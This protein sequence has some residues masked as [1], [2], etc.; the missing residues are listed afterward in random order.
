MCNVIKEGSV[1]QFA[2]DT[3]LIT[4]HRDIKVAE[5]HMQQNF[6]LICKWAHDV[7]LVINSNK[8]K[9]I[10]IRSSHNTADYSI[11]VITHEH[12]CFHNKHQNC[13]CKA[14]EIVQQ[15][16]YLGLIIDERFNWGPHIQHVCHK[17][18]AI[19]SKLAILKY[20]VPYKILRLIYLSMADSIIG[21]GLSS[22]GKTYKTYL[23]YIYKLQ[24]SILKIIVP[25]K[26]K[27]ECKKNNDYN[28][29]FNYC[30]ILSIFDKTKL[31]TLI[32]E[33]QN[34]SKLNKKKRP[35]RLRN[36][37]YQK[38][39]N[40]PKVNNVYGQ[41]TWMYY[42]PNVL[43]ELPLEMQNIF[44]TTDKFSSKIKNHF[45]DSYKRTT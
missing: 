37:L 8:T 27:L 4:A 15:H 26:V 38:S 25:K 39:F 10:H 42:L 28:D 12:D 34:K 41:R 33:N 24:I 9:L 11:K 40:L 6:D 44:V 7:G 3:C 22:Y 45:I 1:Y 29:L 43:N 19:Q 21:Y 14:L 36:I 5:R 18:R 17:L 32:E 23:D 20:K 2:D 30:K 31:H 13:S 16:K 35:D